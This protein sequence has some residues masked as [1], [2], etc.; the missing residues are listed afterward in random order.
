MSKLS[1]ARIAA[2]WR[3]RPLATLG[4][5]VGGTAGFLLGAWLAGERE[6]ALAQAYQCDG[7][8]AAG[9][10]RMLMRE[11][12]GVLAAVGIEWFVSGPRAVKLANTNPAEIREQVSSL[13]AIAEDCGLPVFARPA[14]QVKP[15][16]TDE[17]LRR[18]GLIAVTAGMP[19]H[20]RDG[21]RCGL[22]TAVLDC[23]LPD[24]LSRRGHARLVTPG[25]GRLPH[26]DDRQEEMR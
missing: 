21:G 17:R 14:G 11:Y 10:M 12:A 18:A 6:A 20:A 13:S 8:A 4:I 23:G 24:P 3:A 5:D 16:A 1:P 19:R 9:L 26:P 15:W 22:Y 2:I 7:A 25:Q